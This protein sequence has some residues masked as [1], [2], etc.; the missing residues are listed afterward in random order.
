MCE[1]VS[2]CPVPTKPH[3]LPVELNYKVELF[4]LSDKRLTLT[5]LKHELVAEMANKSRVKH[6]AGNVI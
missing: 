3:C 1:C 6:E 4:L 5:L 2:V